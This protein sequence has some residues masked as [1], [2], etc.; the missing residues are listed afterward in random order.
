ML[1]LSKWQRV[2]VVVMSS[3]Q[4]AA[5]A[6]KSRYAGCDVQATRTEDALAVL[7]KK[8]AHTL[9]SSRVIFG[10]VV[11]CS[12]GGELGVEVVL[13]VKVKRLRSVLNSPYLSAWRNHVIC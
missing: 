6:A 12:A 7:S 8:F 5:L 3:L 1:R 10:L 9:C 13:S 2:E 11:I 4:L